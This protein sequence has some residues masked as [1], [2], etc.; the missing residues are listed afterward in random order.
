MMSRIWPPFWIQCT[1]T[2]ESISCTHGH[3][4]PSR[5]H[6]VLFRCLSPSYFFLFRCHR[7]LIPIFRMY[8]LSVYIL[9]G[10]P[11]YIIMYISYVFPMVSISYFY[12]SPHYVIC[13]LVHWQS[14]TS[15]QSFARVWAT[16]IFSRIL[17]YVDTGW[18]NRLFI[19]L[20]FIRFPFWLDL[21]GLSF[22]Y[23]C[24]GEFH[25]V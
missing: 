19:N 2:P 17:F 4:S 14:L 10:F 5:S 24:E 11:M 18:F 6:L 21:T 1:L 23:Y 16:S 13:I 12:C 20:S 9:H 7:Y 15:S 22:Y 8:F 25:W 3:I